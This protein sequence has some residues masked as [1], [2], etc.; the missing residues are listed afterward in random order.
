MA[1]PITSRTNAT[2]LTLALLKEHVPTVK[3]G[4]EAKQKLA[5]ETITLTAEDKK[6]LLHQQIKGSKAQEI[7]I[8]S[9]L[10]LIKNI[11][12]KEFQRR[13]AWST[14]ISYDDVLQEAIAG[15]IRGLLS[16][17]ETTEHNSPINYL[18]MWVTTTIRR[19]VEV[20]E[21]DF[22]IPYEVVERARRIRAVS[23]RLN[24]ELSRPPTDDELLDALNNPTGHNRNVRWGA[25]TDTTPQTPTRSKKFTQQHLDEARNMASKSYALQPYETQTNDPEETY[26]KASQPLQEQ[27]LTISEYTYETEDLNKSRLKFFTQAFMHMHIGANQQDIILRTFGLTPYDEEQSQ[28]LISNE[29]G[30][31]PRFIKNVITTFSTYMAQPG[32]VFHE[33]LLKSDPDL[34]NGLEM[35]WLLP[36]LGEWPPQQKKPTPPPTILT[37]T[38]TRTKTI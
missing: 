10:P 29:T 11:A 18:S 4:Y 34:I 17:D 31:S 8:I 19:K 20:M 15:F 27:T 37:Q 5:D 2:P 9:A 14:R 13:K 6:T 16:Y 30:L 23:S 1:S 12:S 26:E 25:S 35:T 36:R 33:L 3:N 24:N 28:K 22:S 32:G 21:H 7:L 38:T